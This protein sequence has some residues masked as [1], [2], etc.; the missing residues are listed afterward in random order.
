M[1]RARAAVRR[2]ARPSVIA[3]ATLASLPLALAVLCAGCREPAGPMFGFSAKGAAAERTIE[4]RFIGLPDA[5]RI[6]AELR[7]YAAA[8]HVAG[9]PRDR[10]LMEHTREGFVQAGLESV[11]VTTHDV[12]LPWPGESV[13]EVVAPVRWRAPMTEAGVPGDPDTQ[14]GPTLAGPPFHAYSASGDVVAPLVYAGGGEPADYARLRAK[15]VSIGGRIVLVRSAGPYSY[16]GSKVRNAE[17]AGAAAAILFSNPSDEHPDGGAA[18]PA[19]PW[20]PPGRIQ[21]GSVAYD[22]LT[23]GDPL[24]PGW[25]SVPGARRIPEREAP[26]LPRIPSVPLSY[27]T[28]MRLLAL[29]SPTVRVRVRL[30]QAVRPVWT[31]TGMVRGWE[32]PDDVVILGNHR[33]AWTF[34]GVDPSGGS[35]ALME[36]ARALGALRR[37]GW[38]PRR[39][40]LLASWDAEEFALISST[41]WGEQHAAEL[42]RGAVAYIN[43]DSGVSGPRFTASAVPALNRVIVESTRAVRDPWTGASVAGAAVERRAIERGA[44]RGGPDDAFVEN[45]LGGGLD[46]TVFLNHLGLPVADVGFTGPYG[47]YHSLYDTGTWMERFGDP[48]FRGHAA[49]A[50]VWGVLA[51][52]LADAEALPLDYEAYAGRLADF[53]REL[54]GSAACLRTPLAGDDRLRRA[55]ERLRA[56]AADFARVREAALTRGDRR[57]LARLNRAILGVER[58][59]LDEAGLQGRP[60]YRHLVYAPRPTYAAEVLPGLLEACESGSPGR[61]AFELGRAARAVERAATI[62]RD[63]F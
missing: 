57:T 59:F 19:G 2:A 39:S 11:E 33:D 9:S 8:P 51:L 44:A 13:V 1:R 5:R 52:R 47:V 25:P 60:W 38:R 53:E 56:A 48:D 61:V 30:D 23:P 31:V 26:A 20:G 15:G 32:D 43:V 36:L 17:E 62:L 35:A 10:L 55:I 34:G 40:I 58:A 29:Q 49:L 50:Q 21:R 46:F 24:T 28:A 45:R 16:R 14:I 41:E 18:Y 27:D 37:S 54:R 7:L 3:A 12:L 6:R 22:F 63:A 42:G 4:R